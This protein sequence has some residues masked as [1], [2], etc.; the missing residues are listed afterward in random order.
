[1]LNLNFARE[2]GLQTAIKEGLQTEL[3]TK[4]VVTKIITSEPMKHMHAMA[5]PMHVRLHQFS[6][7]GPEE[8]YAETT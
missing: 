6:S 8:Y 4:M 2:V 3:A 5:T 7:L 1:V